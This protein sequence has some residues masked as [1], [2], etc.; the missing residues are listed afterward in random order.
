MS[1]YVT[2][3]VW[4]RDG[5]CV[6]VCVCVCVCAWMCFQLL[7][8]VW[9]ELWWNPRQT[10]GNVSGGLKSIDRALTSPGTLMR[11]ATPSATALGC[12]YTT[13]LLQQQDR[14]RLRTGTT[15]LEDNTDM[16]G[17]YELWDWDR[18]MK[19]KLIKKH[20]QPDRWVELVYRIKEG[21]GWT[22]SKDNTK[23]VQVK[24][25]LFNPGMLPQYKK[26]C[27][28]KYIF[29]LSGLTDADQIF[30][31]KLCR[32]VL[33][34]LL[35]LQPYIFGV[36]MYCEGCG[37]A[38]T[39]A[40]WANIELYSSQSWSSSFFHCP[41]L[42]GKPAEQAWVPVDSMCWDVFPFTSA[43]VGMST[44]PK[45][46]NGASS[47]VSLSWESWGR[48]LLHCTLASTDFG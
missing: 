27:T 14:I 45:G 20:Y 30:K 42:C 40:G 7:M 13:L 25:I 6:C 35:R 4:E 15:A 44:N 48:M 9:T 16:K 11:E 21:Q 46:L 26:K 10:Q 28:L 23:W 8:L 36:L 38:N 47:G 41:F 22:L 24:H 31:A 1:Y 5:G 39:K 43:K 2:V 34:V 29:S 12:L 3:C 32:V 19:N 18:K 37:R 33:N 17:E